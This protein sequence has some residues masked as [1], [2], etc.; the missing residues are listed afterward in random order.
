MLEHFFPEHKLNPFIEMNLNQK[1][2]KNKEFE[3]NMFE[4]LKSEESVELVQ[5]KIDPLTNIIVC[6]SE[7]GEKITRKPEGSLSFLSNRTI[8]LTNTKFINQVFAVVNYVPE[9][10]VSIPKGIKLGIEEPEE[11]SFHNKIYT[12]PKKIHKRENEESV[13]GHII[14]NKF[15]LTL[16]L[17]LYKLRQKTSTLTFHTGNPLF[18]MSFYPIYHVGSH[19]F[20]LLD[21]IYWIEND[22]IF[23]NFNDIF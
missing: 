20:A 3:P 2:I 13:P 23:K 4:I 19:E 12:D 22:E 6:T 14:Y 5:Q 9:I 1:F 17:D 7:N 10:K 16:Y 21:N 11:S 8:D 15:Y 18:E